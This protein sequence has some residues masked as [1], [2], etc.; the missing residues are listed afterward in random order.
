MFSFQLSGYM[1]HR[2]SFYPESQKRNHTLCEINCE[3][4]FKCQQRY[5]GLFPAACLH[6]F[7]S[8]ALGFSFFPQWDTFHTIPGDVANWSTLASF[9]CSVFMVNSLVG[10]VMNFSDCKL[11]NPGTEAHILFTGLVPCPHRPRTSL[12][13]GLVGR[14]PWIA[15][16]SLSRSSTRTGCA[17]PMRS[18]SSSMTSSWRPLRYGKLLIHLQ[19]K[20]GSDLFGFI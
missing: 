12:C 19:G 15:R 13:T 5:R 2:G 1:R 17:S 9:C 18:R 3:V 11:E 8:S 4:L 10:G 20:M 16:P 6:C 14:R 7:F